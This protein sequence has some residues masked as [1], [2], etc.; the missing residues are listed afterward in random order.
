VKNVLREYS[1]NH[2]MNRMKEIILLNQKAIWQW[3]ENKYLV[4]GSDLEIPSGVSMV[5]PTNV[6]IQDGHEA[7]V[8]PRNPLAAKYGI[9]ISPKIEN[10]KFSI[11]V[12]NQG[13]TTFA[14]KEKDRIAHVFIVKTEEVIA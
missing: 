2:S 11:I 9:T 8:H 10:G 14:I 4:A 3:D 6:I 12:K 1:L 5:L 7:I 13:N